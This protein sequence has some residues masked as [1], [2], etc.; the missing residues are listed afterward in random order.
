M[1]RFD[2]PL[3]RII[4]RMFKVMRSAGGVGLAAV[5]VG[6][7]MRM[8]VASPT[9]EDDDRRVYVNPRIVETDGKAEL[10]EGC[11]SVP[12]LRC[13]IKRAKKVTIE[14]FDPTGQPIRETGEDLLA[15]I[16][17]HEIDHLDGVLIA[18]CM[19]TVAELTNRRL[20]REL[21]E[22]YVQ[23]EKG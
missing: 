12:G 9:G 1:E 18:D 20:L 2:D 8:F 14:A 23:K 21:E 7:D 11:L 3:P 16:F 4:S 19:G 13:K 6:L 5:Q 15:R 10:E 17:Q 22:K